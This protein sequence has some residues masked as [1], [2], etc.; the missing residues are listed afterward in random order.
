MR[1]PFCTAENGA[2]GVGHPDAA[3][4]RRW[5]GE[6]GGPAEMQQALLLIGKLAGRPE[7]LGLEL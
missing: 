7:L 5:T 3:S 4:R 1:L 2:G 6:M